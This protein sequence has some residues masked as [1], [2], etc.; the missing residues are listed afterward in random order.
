[1]CYP[2]W[3]RQ[4]ALLI[5]KKTHGLIQHEKYYSEITSFD[6]G[7]LLSAKARKGSECFE[8]VYGEIEFVSFVNLMLSVNLKHDAVFYDLGSGKGGAVILCAMIFDVKKSCG[9]EQFE[10]LHR[11]AVKQQV[12]LSDTP[13]YMLK[14]SK[15][16]FKC[17]DF[18]VENMD[19]ATVIF[20][21]ST[22]FFGEYWI[23]ICRMLEKLPL[24]KT[25]ITTSKPMNSDIF[26]VIE[27]KEVLMSWGMVIA[28]IHTRAI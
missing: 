8:D 16:T 1:M 28:Y 9:I 22:A 26:S 14:A 13:D 19:D 24:C 7:Y 27:K 10:L 20:I 21:N 3:R 5:W 23:N 18:L 17:G 11:A 12:Y 4:K 6:N 2:A 15:I 25:I